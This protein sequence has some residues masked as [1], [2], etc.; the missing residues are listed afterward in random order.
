MIDIRNKYHIA[1][2][3]VGYIIQNAP[4]A[5]SYLSFQ[6]QMFNN[7]L[8]QG[9]RTYDDFA[10][11][12]FWA[13][14][15]WKNGIKDSMSFEDDARFYLS[16]NI[17]VWSENGAMKLAH[18]GANDVDFG[19]ASSPISCA[20][21]FEVGGILKRYVGTDDHPTSHKPI[22]YR[23]TIGTGWADISSVQ[24]GTGQNAISR[25][26]ARAGILLCGTVGI[27][28]TNVFLT[29]TDTTWTDQTAFLGS[30]LSLTPM[31]ARCFADAAGTLF[32]FVD[33]QANKTWALVKATKANPTANADWTK[34][35]ELAN[36]SG[37]P[38]D[39]VEYLGNL[40]YILNYTGYCELW[41][42]N[43]VGATAT[44]LQTFQN[45]NVSNAGVSGK[46]LSLVGGKLIITIPSN[47]IWMLSAGA[48]TRIFLKDPY[49]KSILSVAEASAY[50]DS[51]AIVTDNKAWWGNLMFDGAA[52]FNTYKPDGD[53]SAENCK[54]L[55][56]DSLG[57]HYFSDT[58]DAK[59]LWVLD[60]NG[61][62]FKGDT[63]KN[64]LI[65]SN[66]DKISGVDKMAFGL[67]LIFNKLVTGQGIVVE[68]NTGEFVSTTTGW[69]ALGD[70]SYAADGGA[71]TQKVLYFPVN[72]K[73]KKIW[74]RV[75]L[76]SGGTNTPSVKDVVMTYLPTP[77]VESEW[78]IHID[79]GDK[80]ELLDKSLEVRRGRELMGSLRYSW[81]KQEELDFQDVDFFSTTLVGGIDASVTDIPALDTSLAPERGRLRID[82]EILEYT[83]KTQT[84][85]KGCLRGLKGTS[86]ATHA[87]KAV[88]HN[89]YKVVISDFRSSVP[90]INNDKKLEYVVALGLRE[91]F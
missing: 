76:V 37:I 29:R 4:E 71:V 17:D 21:E 44:K 2:N 31:A 6:A 81:R 23:Y 42:F 28:S 35:M 70:A 13:Q 18:K 74:L 1:L 75:K 25:V 46:L 64:Y 66:H 59:K 19:T 45:T 34:V 49:K 88:A 69:T 32:V 3:D 65:F 9:D 40:Y 60:P 39:C 91:V 51:G 80:I 72:T 24:F 27:S 61:S 22:L 12:W 68:Y 33:D 90:I 86:A 58:V 54:M 38:V 48:L 84:S 62:L 43:V 52:F 41:Q 11:W 53:S 79:C 7:R 67:T 16:T 85:F 20:G 57:K 8:A 77:D 14:T 82:D 56:A 83:S 78:S 47:E 36:T 63:D 5:P 15:D 50:L 89:G 73:F 26:S 55:F 87:D 30:T 10:K